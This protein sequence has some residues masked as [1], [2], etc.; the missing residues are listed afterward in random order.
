MGEDS[1]PFDWSSIT[2]AATQIATGY[3]GYK[4]ATEQAKATA[5]LAPY[6]PTANYPGMVP[7]SNLPMGYSYP[8]GYPTGTQYQIPAKTDNTLL[9][10]AGG[11]L[12]LVLLL[13]MTGS[14]R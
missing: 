1:T 5:K 7:G 9:W 3:F 13:G 6:L 11:A 4:T 14:K 2:K 10:V 12:G 8:S